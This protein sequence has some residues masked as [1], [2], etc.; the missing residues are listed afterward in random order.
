M[1]WKRPCR[2]RKQGKRQGAAS[3]ARILAVLVSDGCCPF[4]AA[5]KLKELQDHFDR[6]P[7]AGNKVKILEQLGEAQ[8]T[9]A[10]NADKA[11]D[12]SA[13]GLTFEKYR[14]N[15]RT[16]FE[17]LK[18]QEPDA[19]RHGVRYRQL[20]LQVRRGIREVEEMLII[21]AAGR[22]G[23]RWRLCGRI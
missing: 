18:K 16:A 15:V 8:F 10:T 4:V 21:V 11:E 6:E 17:L 5:D 13:V 9:A 23:R 3:C 12:Y 20:E 2:R 22:C 1:F 14:D 7:H 19:D